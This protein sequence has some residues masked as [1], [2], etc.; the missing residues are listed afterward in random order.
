MMGTLASVL[1]KKGI[2]THKGMYEAK[3]IGDIE[4]VNGVL[5]ITRIKVDYFLKVPAKERNDAEEAFNSYLS[6]CPGAQSVIGCIE[7]EHHLNAEDI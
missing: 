3:V 5:K 4:D 6:Y 7:I 2:K 1:A